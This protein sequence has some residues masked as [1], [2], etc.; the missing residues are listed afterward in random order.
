VADGDGLEN[1]CGSNVTVGSNPTPSARPRKT[2]SD[3]DLCL[4]VS[5]RQLITDRSQMQPT[6]AI[7][8]WSRDIRG[9]DLAAFPQVTLRKTEGGR[10]ENDILA[11]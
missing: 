6:A 10:A 9:M 7:S 1:H 3:L 2:G 5:G 8:R 4:P 11:S